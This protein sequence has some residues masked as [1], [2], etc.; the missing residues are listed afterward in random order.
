M[1]DQ[2]DDLA[3]IAHPFRSRVKAVVP[4]RTYPKWTGWSE[5]L[6]TEASLPPGVRT[7]L[8]DTFLKL[9]DQRTSDAI[10]LL[11]DRKKERHDR[12]LE[13]RLDAVCN[14]YA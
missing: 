1:I 13:K 4:R 2:T 5:D 6:Y 3:H 8:E 12:G 7:Y 9:V 14:V 11:E 10:K